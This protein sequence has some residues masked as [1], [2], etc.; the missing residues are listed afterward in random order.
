MTNNVT[1]WAGGGT[2]TRTD[3]TA[4]GYSRQWAARYT[5]G[6]FIT[7]PKGSVTPGLA[8]TVSVY[9]RPESFNMSGT[10]WIEWQNGSG[11][12]ISS[13]NTGFSA[14]SGTITRA[15][16][17]GT[18]PTGAATVWLVV[19]GENYASNATTYTQCLI[20]QASSAGTYFDGGSPGASWTGTAGNST[21]TLTDALT[22]TLSG[23]LPV[24]TGSASATVTDSGT[25]A[26]TLPVLTGSV[27]TSVKDSGA[28]TG[29]LPVLTGTGA[30][31]VFDAATLSGAL[32]P[33]SGSLAA[34]AATSGSLAGS[35][36]PATGALGGSATA[37]GALA[38][39]LPT[40]T[41]SLLSDIPAQGPLTTALPALAGV[42]TG[43]AATAGS[44][45]GPLPALTAFLDGIPPDLIRPIRVTVNGMALSKALTGPS[46]LADPV[47]SGPDVRLEVTG[48]AVRRTVTGIGV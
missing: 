48:P 7:S 22:G 35:L 18:A 9:L 25:L 10:I 4:F 11:S 17:T 6:S 19:T 8:Y 14:P 37:A 2:P 32:P 21:S 24:L 5:T 36:P 39:T 13:T 40:L 29:T 1:G 12:T 30:G 38:G 15:S 26:G 28:L 43:D 41:A 16:M 34:A 42:L 3:V 20:E 45:A 46:V 27:S 33:L 31:S 47:P 44:L 23:T